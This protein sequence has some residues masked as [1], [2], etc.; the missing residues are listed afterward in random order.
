MGFAG[1]ILRVVLIFAAGA[2]LEPVLAG[3]FTHESEL[4]ARSDAR[5]AA[6]VGKEATALERLPAERFMVT[7]DSGATM[8]R[9]EFIEWIRKAGIKPFQVINESIVLHGDTAVVIGANSERTVK[10]TWVAVKNA[11]RWRVVSEIFSRVP[12]PK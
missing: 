6:E 9:A 11:E 5:I 7:F 4:V 1:H 3:Q 8:N 10:F 12:A 2:M